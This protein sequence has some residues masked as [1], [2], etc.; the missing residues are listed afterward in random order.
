MKGNWEIQ[1]KSN[2][3]DGAS[4]VKFDHSIR[5]L[6]VGDYVDYDLFPYDIKNRSKFLMHENHPKSLNPSSFTYKKYWEDFT[7]K[8]LEGMWVYD[9]G[10]WVYMMPEL[11]YY[12]N[13]TKITGNAD[14]DEEDRSFISPDLSSTEWVIFSYIYAGDRFSGFELDDKYTC[15]RYVESMYNGNEINKYDLAKVKDTIYQKNGQL[16]VFVDP[17]EYLTRFY[18]IDNPRGNLGAPLYKN[19]FEDS[20]ITGSRG[21]AKSYC[22]YGGKFPHSWSFGTVRTKDKIHECCSK[23]LFAMGCGQKDP[24]NRSLKIIK[25]FY[26]AQPGQY[27]FPDPKRP[28]HRGPLYKRVQGNW[29]AGSEIEHVIKEKNDSKALVGSSLQMNVITP[30]RKRIAAG[31]R[32]LGLM[33]EEGGFLSY[34]PEVW[35]ANRNSM[36][37]SGV[38]VGRAFVTGTSGDLV[39]VEGIKK[40]MENPRAYKITPIPNYWKNPD[41]EI[42]LFLSNL[43]AYRKYK[44]PQG[45][46]DLIEALKHIAGNR[47]RNSETMDSQQFDDFILYE[48]IHPDEMLRPNKRSI[49]PGKQA[50]ERLSDIDAFGY[51]DLNATVGTFKFDNSQKYGVDFVKDN[52]LTPIHDYNIDRN[53]IK[54]EGAAVVYEHPDGYIPENLYWVIFDPVSKPGRGESLDASL[55]SIIVYKWMYTGQSNTLEDSIVAEW[56][57]RLDSL[58]DTYEIV[59]KMAKYFN[60]K[61]FPETNTPGFVAWCNTN[62]YSHMLQSEAVIAIKELYPNYKQKLGKVG[63][64]IYGEKLKP[65]LLLRLRQW[66]LTKRGLD[67]DTGAFDCYNI[68]T[69][70]SKRLLNEIVNFNEGGNFDHISSMLGLMLLRTQLTGEPPNIEDESVSNLNIGQP[71]FKELKSRRKRR[72][73]FEETSYM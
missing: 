22:I 1:T 29:E 52:S 3:I 25:A 42:G 34:L 55:N 9:E 60:A 36:E 38:K 13:Y 10:T 11:F 58:E 15:H 67:E 4:M 61:I 33:F 39:G 70:L 28:K 7:I 47:I 18:L 37:V 46:S 53:R 63:F 2:S 5:K 8:C 54:L 14:G 62:S 50:Q 57:G 72:S 59:V 24:L 49:L 30:D 26:D 27:S 40:L 71:K 69:I 51:Y 41:K 31:D 17:W 32:F 21:V 66:L 48:P 16:K 65:W 35:A 6:K 56:I 45:N 73:S 12:I 44:D 43:Y 23:N 20:C 68:D 64:S 19:Q